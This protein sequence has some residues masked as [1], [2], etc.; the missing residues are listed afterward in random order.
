MLAALMVRAGKKKS[1]AAIAGS[2]STPALHRRE[3]ASTRTLL[4]EWR[5]LGLKSPAR[6]GS[7]RR[8][9]E[10]PLPSHSKNFFNKEPR[11]LCPGVCLKTVVDNSLRRFSFELMRILAIGDVHGC[12]VALEEM[13]GLVRFS[14][15]DIIIPLGDYVDRGPDSK[16]VIDFLIDLKRQFPKV[17]C[18]RGNHEIMMERARDDEFEARSWKGFGGKEALQSYDTDSL[19]DIPESHWSFI[20]DLLPY[21]ETD[22]YFFVHANAYPEVALIDQPDYMLYWDHIFETPA[23]HESGK[24]MICGHTSQKSGV[25]LNFGHAVCIDTFAYGGG[26]LTCLD[27][28][29][30]C[31]WQTNEKREH[32]ADVLLNQEL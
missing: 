31:Y 19:E 7:R 15:D 29:T 27:V 24:T 30:G 25:P 11:S 28:L 4:T 16:G 17:H 20:A 13:A 18:L 1:L 3:P 2:K 12:R 23:K 10:R 21:Y 26:W 9:A 32:R 22:D 8:S 14:K 5:S 6:L